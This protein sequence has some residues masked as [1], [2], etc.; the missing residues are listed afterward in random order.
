MQ[1]EQVRLRPAPAAEVY[2]CFV[3]GVLLSESKVT[4][5][6]VTGVGVED[7]S[8]SRPEYNF[9]R[10]VTMHK[11]LSSYGMVVLFAVMASVMALPASAEVVPSKTMAGQDLNERQ[12]DLVRIQNFVEMDQVAAVLA[13]HGFSTQQ[14]NERLAQL[15]D[16]DIQS[17][18]NNLDQVQAAGLTTTQWTYVLLGAVVVLLLIL[19]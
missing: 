6:S 13:Q 19:L 14:V 9:N 5:E 17:L 4:R 18:A 1:R 12:A 8:R 11:R 7:G 15:S 2:S 3:A 16:E 10:E